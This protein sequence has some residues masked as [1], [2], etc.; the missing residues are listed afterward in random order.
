MKLEE[1]DSLISE[2]RDPCPHENCVLCHRAADALEECNKTIQQLQKDMSV[3]IATAQPYMDEAQSYRNAARLYGIDADTMLT[4][5]KS[6]IKTCADNIRIVE[7]MQSVLSIFDDV[8]QDLDV[9]KV[10]ETITHYDGDNSKPGCDLVYCGLRIIWDYLKERSDLDE[11]RKG[12]LPD[13][14]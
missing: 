7:K 1:I 12:N 10:I 9:Q 8:P 4:L 2:L 5:A 6:Q 14:A 3:L 11:W 13:F